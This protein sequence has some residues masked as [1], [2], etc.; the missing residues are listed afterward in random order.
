MTQLDAP[1]GCPKIDRLAALAR[2]GLRVPT[3]WVL[4]T[5]QATELAISAI[6]ERLGPQFQ[7]GPLIVRMAT[8]H[9]DGAHQSGAGLGLSI[10]NC[11]TPLDL[12][13]AL[14]DIARHASEMGVDADEFAVL[15]QHQVVDALLVV[16]TATPDVGRFVEVHDE[17]DDALAQGHTPSFSGPLSHWDHV[18]REAVDG[19]L[20]TVAS[21]SEDFE[22]LGVELEIVVDRAAIPYLVQARPVTRALAPRW[23]EFQRVAATLDDGHYGDPWSSVATGRWQLDAEHNPAP[24]SPAHAWL[25]RELR[26]RRPRSGQPHVIAGWLYMQSLPRQLGAAPDR[27][28]KAMVVA[29]H[30]EHLPAARRRLEAIE[31]ALGSAELNAIAEHLDEALG[32]FLAMIDLY[33]GELAR[34]R[35]ARRLDE[36]GDDVAHSLAD[37]ARHCDVLPVEWDL[38]SETLV[39]VIDHIDVDDRPIAIPDDEASASTLLAEWDDHLFA[40]G[41]RP[42]A[43]VFHRA[44][45]LLEVPRADVFYLGGDE[46]V[47]AA[48]VGH[49]QAGIREHITARRTARQHFARLSPPSHLVDGRPVPVSRS[50]RFRGI[51]VGSPAEGL[52]CQVRDLRDLQTRAITPESV[53]CVPALTAQASVLLSRLRVAAV[54]TEHGGALSHATLMTREL[55]L[56]ALIGCRGC[57]SLDDGVH[58]RVDTKLG[59]LLVRS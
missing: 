15:I 36:H 19:L 3:G 9:E 59:R 14:E 46:L 2:A 31:A 58:V 8:K 29:L 38:D 56:S 22:A 24:V 6:A 17:I 30:N 21:S 25:L 10:P 32:A 48:R 4:T 20:T 47:A 16:A 43:R 12:V 50:G 44:A 26:R 1:T 41:M 49:L 18:A 51:P 42:L 54:C 35:H 52:V 55:G 23:R 13:C 53:V 39:D 34:A 5:T 11:L 7:A 27:S 33:L 28:A 37:R 57:T 45:T 40:L